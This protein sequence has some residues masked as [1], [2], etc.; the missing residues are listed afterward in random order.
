M[1][2]G[3]FAV[4]MAAKSAAP[5][6]SLGT[7][8]LAAQ[9]LD[10][11]WPTLLLIGLEKVE[12]QPGITRF[13]PLDFVHY[14]IS[15]SLLMAVAWGLLFGL[16]Y[17][18][19]GKYRQGAIVLGIGVLSHW[20]LDLVAHRPDLP[21]AFGDSPRFGLGLWN[22]V[23]GTMAVEAL[24]LALGVWL[25]LRTTRARNRTGLFAFWGLIAFLVVIFLTN[26]FGPPPPNVPA[27]AW[28]G[29]LQWLF[30]LWGYWIDRNREVREVA[31][32]KTA[33]T[34]AA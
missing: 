22:S 29:H 23:P 3:H 9:F 4:G 5:R 2:L 1:F 32:T 24:L 25:Y 19:A 18:L 26:A 6:T 28:A 14:P 10:L 16:V 21:L 31:G 30:V 34:F 20:I 17:W 11:L 15:H 33:R 7:L 27:I 12:I 8:I 13:T